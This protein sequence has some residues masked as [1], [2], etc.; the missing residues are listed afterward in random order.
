[1]VMRAIGMFALI[2]GTISLVFWLASTAAVPH[3]QAQA[4]AALWGFVSA[5]TWGLSVVGNLIWTSLGLF[6]TVHWNSWFNLI[7]AVCAA[8]AVGYATI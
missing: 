1:M 3:Q 8:T 5:L 6:S 2:V 7:A 4:V